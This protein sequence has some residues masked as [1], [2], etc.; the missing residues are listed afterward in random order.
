MFQM[1]L[2]I[3]I[4]HN[5]QLIYVPLRAENQINSSLIL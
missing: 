3:H 4:T 1:E 5:S 2:I